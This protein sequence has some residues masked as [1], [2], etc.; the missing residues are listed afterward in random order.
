VRHDAVVEGAALGDQRVDFLG[1]KE[2]GGGDL[3]GRLPQL[4]LVVDTVPVA[5]GERGPRVV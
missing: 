1:A 3:V 4:G 2:A 5:R